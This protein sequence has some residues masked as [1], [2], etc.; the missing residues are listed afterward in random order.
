MQKGVFTWPDGSN[1]QGEFFENVMSGEG[2]LK[3]TDPP[4]IIK[5]KWINGVL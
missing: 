1:Y 2:I 5:G 3:L 4:E